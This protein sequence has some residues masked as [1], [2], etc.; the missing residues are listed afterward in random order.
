MIVAAPASVVLTADENV[1]LALAVYREAVNAASPYLGFIAL[2]GVL[3]AVLEKRDAVDAYI[4]RRHQRTKV[5]G[6]TPMSSPRCR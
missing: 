2:R 6:C 3:D 5:K 4:N 1:R